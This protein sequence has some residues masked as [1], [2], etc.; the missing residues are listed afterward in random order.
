MQTVE[1]CLEMA[2]V[3][4]CVVLGQGVAAQCLRNASCLA[5]LDGEQAWQLV[6][7]ASAWQV[8]VLR[9]PVAWLEALR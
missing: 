5:A 9:E 1:E 7:W 6:C 8:E 4:C 3:R 2:A